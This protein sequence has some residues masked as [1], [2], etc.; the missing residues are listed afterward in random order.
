MSSRNTV[1]F[2]TRSSPE[3]DASST[4]ARL[5]STRFV[6]SFMSPLTISRVIGSSASCPA[7]NTSSPAT[8]AWLYGPIAAGAFA[9]WMLRMSSPMSPSL[10]ECGDHRA[11]EQLVILG[12]DGA[13]VERDPPVDDARHDGRTRGAQLSDQAGST[14]RQRDGAGELGLLRQRATADR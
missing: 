2:T 9:V 6:C 14:A 3:P 7:Q 5:S 13:Q 4:A 10:F 8:M 12:K 11:R 1:V